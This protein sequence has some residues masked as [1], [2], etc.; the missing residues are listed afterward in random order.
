MHSASELERGRGG[1]ESCGRRGCRLEFEIRRT[2]GGRSQASLKDYR[3][4]VSL[5]S[6]PRMLAYIQILRSSS[7]P[8]VRC[9]RAMVA[10]WSSTDAKTGGAVPPAGPLMRLL[11]VMAPVLLF[12]LP[13]LWPPWKIKLKPF[14]VRSGRKFIYASLFHCSPDTEA[15]PR[16]SSPPLSLSPKQLQL[17]FFTPFAF[18]PRGWP[19]SER[20]PI[21]LRVCP[22]FEPPT[23]ISFRKK[24]FTHTVPAIYM[25]H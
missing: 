9:G 13:E 8:L 20:M 21:T 3:A 15:F 12:H 4:H 22:S 19:C 23:C 6:R 11:S 14:V 2:R 16:N 25:S 7:G 17:L 1:Y 24:S 5:I 10:D 18:W